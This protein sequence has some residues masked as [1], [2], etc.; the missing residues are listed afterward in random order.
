M[1]DKE[2][3]V[4]YLYGELQPAERETFETHAASC[5]ECA[6]EVAA[7]RS[8]RSHL[9]SWTPPE[10]ALAFQIVRGSAAP[11]A[12]RRSPL[13]PAWGLAAAAVL[14]LAAA[15]A[16]ANIEVV[17]GNDGLRVRTGWARAQ[18]VPVIPSSATSVAASADA[19]SRSEFRLLDERL[20]GLEAVAAGREASAPKA[21]GPRLSESELLRQVRQMLRD[22]E[23]RQERELALRIGQVNRD[24][25][26]IRRADLLRIQQGLAQ[27]QGLT[28]TTMLRQRAMEDHLYRVVQ[29]PKQ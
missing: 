22:S 27:I 29:Q 17:Y 16:L 5:P 3:L 6:A 11:S 9:S 15:S 10:P 8:T 28:G 7:L 1:C 18:E 25:E 19:V 12:R 21:A 2:L 20:R 24:F 14:V 13:R 23:A 26:A 4:G